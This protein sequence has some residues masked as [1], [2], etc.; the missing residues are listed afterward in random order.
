MQYLVVAAV[1]CAAVIL[2]R[3][4]RVG[5]AAAVSV[6]LRRRRGDGRRLARE[7]LAL[8]A[9]GAAVVGWCGMR[10]TVTLAAALALPT[11]YPHRDLILATAFDVALGTL[12]VQGL[13]LRPLLLR[14]DWAQL[15]RAREGTD[16][17][18]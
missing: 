4:A 5:G 12:V 7:G 1:V 9:R 8:T 10:G 11:V 6:W 16:G 18:P 3:L 15:V 13:T 17:S 2:T 14:V